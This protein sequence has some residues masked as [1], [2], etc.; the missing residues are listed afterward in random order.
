MT[1][2]WQHG[3]HLQ[4]YFL[5]FGRQVLSSAAFRQFFAGVLDYRSKNPVIYS[6]EVGL[7]TWLR[8]SGFRGGAAFPPA[9]LPAAWVADALVRRTWPWVYRK[10]KNP[11]LYYPDRLLAAGMPYL[12]AELLQ[13]HRLLRR[14]L[15]LDRA[16]EG[17]DLPRS[18]RRGR[19]SVRPSA[20][21]G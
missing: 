17:Y 20:D 21:R 13:G 12:K 19:S 9:S 10:N 2:S 8:E 6:Y 16:L 7:S 1:E 18:L 11:T 4:S 15:Q 5:V 3:Q 14:V